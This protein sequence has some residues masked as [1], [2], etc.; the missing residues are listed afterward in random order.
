MGAFMHRIAVAGLACCLVGC[1]YGAKPILTGA[2]NVTSSYSEKVPGK[3]ALY[4]EA[5][6]FDKVIHPRGLQ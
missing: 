6:G 4:V 1:A 5:G 2:V 3:F